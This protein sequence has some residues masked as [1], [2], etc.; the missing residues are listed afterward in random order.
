MKEFS[1]KHTA[2]KVR[3]G[4]EVLFFSKTLKQPNIDNYDPLR[5]KLE[6]G[7]TTVNIVYR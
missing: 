6:K 1:F 3:T 4:Q 7:E 2:Y 5:F